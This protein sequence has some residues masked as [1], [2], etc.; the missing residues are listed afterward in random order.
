MADFDEED[1][2]AIRLAM[3]QK[4]AEKRLQIL[5]FWERIPDFFAEFKPATGDLYSHK[6][7]TDQVL[8]LVREWLGYSPSA[9]LLADA[10]REKGYKPR[11]FKDEYPV[12]TFW[13]FE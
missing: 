12:K 8:D 4:E 2:A 1:E 9:D 11:I 10:F 13:V 6:M 5:K 7:T 3:I